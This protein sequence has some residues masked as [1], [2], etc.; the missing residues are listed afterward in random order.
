[1]VFIDSVRF[2]D[3]A[4]NPHY[5]CVKLFRFIMNGTSSASTVD[6]VLQKVIFVCM[7]VVVEMP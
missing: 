1:M 6:E 7:L 5:F 2:E 3:V 4:L